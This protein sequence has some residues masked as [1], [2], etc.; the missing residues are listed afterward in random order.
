MVGN[1]D[2]PIDKIGVLGVITRIADFQLAPLGESMGLQ[3]CYEPLSWQK[4]N[5]G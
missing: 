5:V 4:M 2:K 3:T 1:P